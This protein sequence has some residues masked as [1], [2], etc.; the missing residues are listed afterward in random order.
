M[1]AFAVKDEGFFYDGK[2][3]TLLKKLYQI[4][5]NLTLVEEIGEELF[6]SIYRSLFLITVKVS[7]L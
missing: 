7:Y 1:N 6:Y 5:E 2:I 3:E 4:P